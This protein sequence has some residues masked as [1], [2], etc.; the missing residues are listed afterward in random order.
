[1]RRIWIRIRMKQKT[2]SHRK[3]W[4]K[5]GIKILKLYLNQKYQKSDLVNKSYNKISKSY[6]E[7]WTDHMQH[8]SQEMLD[9]L[10]L[11]KEGNVLD[12]ACGTGF[13]TGLL[14]ESISGNITG[15][16][17][18][19]GMLQVARQKHGNQCTFVC[20][21][22][23]DYLLKQPSN[24]VDVVT[25]AWGLGYTRPYRVIKEISRI[26]KKRGQVAVID[27]SLFTIF[28]V[29]KS[30][31]LTI[32]EYPMSLTHVMNTRFL[33]TT[34]ALTRRMQLCG[35]RVL[36]SWYGSNTYYAPN[37]NDAL[38]RLM[39]TGT[40]AG[41]PYCFDEQHRRDIAKRFKQIFEERY[42][43]ENGIPIIHRYIA[44]IGK[45]R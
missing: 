24:T 7:T 42:G 43:G 12:L 19:E 32:A 21:D 8:L 17:A 11:P 5:L 1:M 4:M 23:I 13:V 29:V 41:Y 34:G 16:D 38:R 33:S 2:N 45:K 31:I 3:H 36:R 22:I 37:G 35:L 10:T 39:N 25:C 18:S 28:E 6:D 14:A 15:V 44:V 26:L 9:K 20:S 40:A 30:G 27:N